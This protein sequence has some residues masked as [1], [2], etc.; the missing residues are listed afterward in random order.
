MYFW[1]KW[2]HWDRVVG[3]GWGRLKA[4]IEVMIPLDNGCFIADDIFI[5]TRNLCVIADLCFLMSHKP[6]VIYVPVCPS[7]KTYIGHREKQS[8]NFRAQITLLHREHGVCH[9]QTPPWHQTRLSWHSAFHW[10]WTNN[11]SGHRGQST[12]VPV[13][14]WDVFHT[15]WFKMFLLSKFT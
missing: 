9:S 7:G 15:C 11:S 10:T 6:I 3:G 5:W 14:E 1:N 2:S 8:M 4:Q 13:S 12:K